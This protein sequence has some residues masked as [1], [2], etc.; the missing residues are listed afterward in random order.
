MDVA[1]RAVSSAVFLLTIALT[2]QWWCLWISASSASHSAPSLHYQDKK[3]PQATDHGVHLSYSL[4]FSTP[5]FMSWFALY[6]PQ[7]FSFF[8]ALLENMT[9][10]TTVGLEDLKSA[11]KMS[12]TRFLSVPLVYFLHCPISGTFYSVWN[13]LLCS[14]GSQH[15]IEEMCSACAQWLL[16]IKVHSL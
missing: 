16:F 5:C 14:C 13:F 15:L 8:H 9:I 12:S 1:Y 4:F 2:F 6:T 3:V 10:S 11:T 7:V